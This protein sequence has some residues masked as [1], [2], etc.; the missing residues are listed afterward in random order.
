MKEFIFSITLIDSDNSTEEEIKPGKSYQISLSEEKWKEVQEY[1]HKNN[2][3]KLRSFLSS[4]IDMDNKE[5]SIDLD[6]VH[7]FYFV[8]SV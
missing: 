4:F 1:A 8:I 7:S 6:S 3:I 5:W 2:E